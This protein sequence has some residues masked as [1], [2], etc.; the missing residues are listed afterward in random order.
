MT[1]R[2]D[3]CPI[4]IVEI[5]QIGQLQM[6]VETRKPI[7]H[8]GFFRLKHTYIIGKQKKLYMESFCRGLSSQKIP[9]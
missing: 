2:K 8:S 3:L 9:K 7:I 4:L 5:L 6:G 1:R